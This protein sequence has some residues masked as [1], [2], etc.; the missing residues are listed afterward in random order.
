MPETVRN[1]KWLAPILI[2]SLLTGWINSCAADEASATAPDEAQPA[3][4]AKQDA[5]EQL[6]ATVPDDPREAYQLKQRKSVQAL[7]RM[8]KSLLTAEVLAGFQKHYK[9]YRLILTQGVKPRSPDELEA[10]KS[11]LAYRVYT[12]AERSIQEQPV[13]LENAVKSIRREIARAGSSIGNNQQRAQFRE[14]FY[15]EMVPLLEA[16]LQNNLVARSAAIEILPD[17][18]VVPKGPQGRLVMFDKA[19][20][21]LIDI[22]GDPEQPDAVKARAA[23]S[24]NNYLQKTDSIPQVQM[25]FAKAI[26]KELEKPH[27]E[28]AYQ[29]TLL[30]ALEAITTPRELVS[31]NLAVAFAIATKVM[32]DT[33]RDIRIRC[34]AARVFGRAGFDARTDFGVLSW[35]VAQL[36]VDTAR[37]FN[38]SR[39]KSDPKWKYCGF[40]LY[41]AF[42]HWVRTD[43]ATKKGFLNRDDR[44]EA[45]RNAWE[46]VMPV[47]T[48][49]MLNKDLVPRNDWNGIF[50][51]TKSNKPTNLKF[52]P[53]CPPVTVTA[54]PPP[55]AVSAKE[56]D[57]N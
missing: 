46:K 31:P 9:A 32:H 28:V 1:N 4:D 52:D 16:L 17:M 23:N 44:N 5:P 48:H 20:Q 2:L 33:K 53:S 54:A 24:I 51:W 47:A 43:V 55:P 13:D 6:G 27:T 8:D 45:V 18:E 19:G 26:A 37:E 41:T 57:S 56:P 10:L 38:L 15:T 42:H 40:Y 29:E 39:E 50:G 35:A 22:L 14:Q 21:M 12:L 34:H 3:A 49:L 25:A 11:V 30:F 36:T 7:R